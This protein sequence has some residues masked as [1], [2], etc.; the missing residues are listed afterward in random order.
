MN[1]RDEIRARLD[2]VTTWQLAKMAEC[3]DPDRADGYGFD[4]MTDEERAERNKTASA[5]AKFLRYCAWSALDV[6]D[7]ADS[8]AGN[9]GDTLAERAEHDGRLTEEADG[10]VP[11]YTHQ[12]W[13]TFV[14]LCAYQEDTDE[15]AGADSDMSD[16]A[17]IALYMIAERLIRALVELFA[18]DDADEEEDE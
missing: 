3:A 9:P 2:E 16:R 1:T 18:D 13:Q 11:V 15:L 5:G 7:D 17:G 12:R 14:D 10:C 8:Y 4:S 6:L